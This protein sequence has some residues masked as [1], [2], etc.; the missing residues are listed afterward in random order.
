MLRNHER[1][2]VALLVEPEEPEAAAD[3]GDH[4]DDD[5][6]LGVSGHETAVPV[7]KSLQSTDDSIL[8]AANWES[9]FLV[10]LNFFETF[11]HLAFEV[12]KVLSFLP[13]DPLI[14]LNIVSGKYEVLHC[15]I[16]CIS[17]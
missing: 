9:F 13:C 6:R 3:R 4:T 1:G 5:G 8:T 10:Y 17:L 2:S 7:E 14:L 11:T 16:V 15:T 12:K